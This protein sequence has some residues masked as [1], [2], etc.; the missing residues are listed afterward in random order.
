MEEYLK[1]LV[2]SSKDIFF[3]E[4]KS[5][6]HKSINDLLSAADLELND[7]VSLLVIYGITGKKYGTISNMIA[8]VIQYCIYFFV[9]ASF[10]VP[11]AIRVL[12]PKYSSDT[13]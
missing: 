3:K 11:T 7:S 12:T 10:G 13:K 4:H 2:L 8:P 1:Q 5:I 6:K 9:L